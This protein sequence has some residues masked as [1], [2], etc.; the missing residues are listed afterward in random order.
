SESHR[1]PS[2][3]IIGVRKGGTRALLDAMTLHPKIRAVRKEAHFFDLNFSRGIDW[4]RSLMPL[5][6]SDQ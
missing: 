1:L 3:L 6:T 5:S 2:V 4:Y